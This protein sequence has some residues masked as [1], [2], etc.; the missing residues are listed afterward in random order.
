MMHSFKKIFHRCAFEGILLTISGVNIHNFFFVLFFLNIRLQIISILIWN[1]PRFIY[2][3]YVYLLCRD[4]RQAIHNSR[5]LLKKIYYVRVLRFRILDSRFYSA[6]TK[7]THFLLKPKEQ[8]VLLRI[9]TYIY[10]F[11]S[12]FMSHFLCVKDNTIT[13]VGL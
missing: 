8:F 9:Y 2:F 7:S 6:R 3:L 10:F 5:R 4:T 13:I 11:F 1:A 12:F